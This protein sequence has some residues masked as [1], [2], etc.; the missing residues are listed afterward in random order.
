[1]SRLSDRDAIEYLRR[2]YRAADGLWFMKVEERDGF[3][4]ALDV[5]VE[6]WKVMPKIQ[7]R[8]LKSKLHQQSGIDGLRICFEEKLEQDGFLFTTV[9]E[10]NG[11]SIHVQD[12][13]WHNVLKKAGREHLSRAIGRRICSTEFSLW[14]AEFGEHITCT[15]HERICEGGKSCSF[16][17]TEN[18]G[19]TI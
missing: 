16:R 7:A 4:T 9:Q 8:T 6:V 5:D 3:D 18:T 13:P 19:E 17:F 10:N 1:M 15:F 2:C 11:F 14:A 12:C